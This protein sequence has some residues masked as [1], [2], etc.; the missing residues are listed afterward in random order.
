MSQDN[1]DPG[2]RDSSAGGK[3]IKGL[4]TRGGNK[5]RENIINHSGHM[6]REMCFCATSEADELAAVTQLV[7]PLLLLLLF[8]SDPWDL[9]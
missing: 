1:Q 3:R 9:H 5:G 4:W 6:Q 7:Q 8:A 2:L